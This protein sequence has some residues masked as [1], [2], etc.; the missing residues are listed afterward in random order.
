MIKKKKIID[1]MGWREYAQLPQLGVEAIKVKVDTGAR[2]SSLHV[3]EIRYYRRGEK[4]FA[5]F[6][7]HPRQKSSRPVIEAKAEV[8]EHRKVKSSNGIASVRPV[9]LTKLKIG[10]HVKIIELTLVNR[11]MMGFRML[12]GREAIRGEF[13]VDPGKSF[14]MSKELKRRSE[15]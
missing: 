9:I 11:D 4:E 3:S 14:L 1:T 8:V 15:K 6:V 7:I 2:T 10:E 5:H 13:L 12:V